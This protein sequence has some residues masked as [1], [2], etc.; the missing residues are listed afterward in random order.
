MAVDQLLPH[1]VDAEEAVLGSLLIDSEAILTVSLSL[2]TAD[3]YRE[4]N[5]WIYGACLALYEKGEAINQIT[6]AHRLSQ[7]GRL[8]EIGGPAYLSYL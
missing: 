8:E 6:V 1:D 7:D 3:F 2:K 4:R 5:G